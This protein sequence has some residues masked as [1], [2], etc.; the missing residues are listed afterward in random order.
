MFRKYILPGLA[1]LGVVAIY[2]AVRRQSTPVVS[3]PAVL[4]PAINPYKQA[5]SGAGIV[6]P[7]SESIVVSPAIGGIVTD[8]LVKWGQQLKAGDPLYRIDPRPLK[9]QIAAATAEVGIK[10]AALAQARS[11]LARLQAGSRDEDKKIAA[12]SL[13]LKKVEEAD[14]LDQWNR[15][16]KVGKSQAIS[17]DDINKRHFAYLESQAARELEESSFQKVY[18]GSWIQDIQVQEA[19]VKAADADVENARAK[20]ETLQVDLDR[21]IVRAPV[22]GRVL[23]INLRRGEYAP[24]ANVTTA[25]D[26]PVVVGDVDHLNV[27]VDIDEADVP[28]YGQTANAMGFVRGATHR[29]VKLSF[30]RI[31]PFVVP[32]KNLTGANTERVDTRVLQVIYRINREATDVPLYVG[33]QMDVYIEAPADSSATTQPV[34]MN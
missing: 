18:A 23:R 16:Q 28:R 27:R 13:E 15:M 26:G 4:Q 24:A 1:I 31:E 2:W 3:V 17:E 9:A 34:V 11:A 7:E 21:L 29:A 8:V 19:A 14:A 10:Q 12:A 25:S 32:K 33:Q 5:V 30:V 20:L 22:D 6:E